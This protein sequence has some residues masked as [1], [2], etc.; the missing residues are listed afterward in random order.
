MLKLKLV[1]VHSFSK[2]SLISK[3]VAKAE[4]NLLRYDF[5]RIN[6]H[7]DTE[8]ELFSYYKDI[9]IYLYN[10]YEALIGDVSFV[11]SNEIRAFYGHIIE[12]RVA[13]QNDE[14]DIIN[15]N[16]A[17]GHF[18]RLN[19]DT[20]KLLCD[21]YDKFF[22]QYL[23]SRSKYNYNDVKYNF[24][25]NY[26]I[27]YLEARKKYLEA[28]NSERLGSNSPNNV[29]KLYFE[30]LKKYSKLRECYSEYHKRIDRKRR[31]IIVGKVFSLCTSLACSIASVISFF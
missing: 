15:L 11:L 8:K 12:Y 20:F 23:N 5:N 22:I 16:K 29:Y 26:S 10:Y 21:E 31:W 2:K 7:P 13:E 25:K 14:R 27:M 3:K 6:V 30:A 18:R 28:Q 4:N 19:L 1:R 24:L 9:Y 17:Y